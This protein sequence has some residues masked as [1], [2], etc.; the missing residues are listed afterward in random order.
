MELWS[1]DKKTYQL[2]KEISMVRA[3][4]KEFSTYESIYSDGIYNRFAVKH[5]DFR[6][7]VSVDTPF[8]QSESFYWIV[9]NDT[10][11]GGV[12]I[13]PNVISRFFII[14]PYSDIY[15]LIKLLK[16]VLI[17]WS[18]P[19]KNIYAFQIDNDQGRYFKMLGF[20]KEK[21]RRWMMRP[22]EKM[23]YK[24]NNEFKVS[25]PKKTEY[26]EIAEL[27]YRSF[28]NG[29]DLQCQPA[30]MSSENSYEN[31]L[32]DVDDFFDN[33]NNLLLEASSIVYDGEK[34]IGACLVSIFE[35]WPLIHTLAVDP[36][37]SGKGLGKTMLKKAMSVMNEEYSVI[38]LFV[39]TGNAAE[40]VYHELGFVQ[41][42]EFG[43]YYLQ[44]Q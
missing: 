20:W 21:S 29:V 22:T 36:S 41:G 19:S 43:K 38:R 15:G 5:W 30:N 11:I 7:A 34:I 28:D 16:K 3:C 35:E 12:L 37:Y 26:K 14:P 33:T 32:W 44:Q 27:F 9:K 24:W 2:D 6:L 31:Y 42:V 10:R 8:A 18:D 39:T 17:T 13:E 25:S 40:S 4:P 23:D 1:K